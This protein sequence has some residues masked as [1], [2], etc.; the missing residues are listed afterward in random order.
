MS[1]TVVEC[2]NCW[3]VAVILMLKVPERVVLSVITFRVTVT[4]VS[5]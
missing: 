3:L 5:L 2:V 1:V 4:L